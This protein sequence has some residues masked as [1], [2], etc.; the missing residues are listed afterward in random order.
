MLRKTAKYFIN[1]LV[2][3]GPIAI[4][5]YLVVKLF[6]LVDK[7]LGEVIQRH[8][9]VHVYGLGF[10]VTML[11]AV[12]TLVLAGF[13]STHYLARSL[14]RALEGWVGRFPLIK[15]VYNS[16]KDLIGAFVGAKKRFDQPVFVTII[17]GSEAKVLGFVTRRSVGV[18]GL[19][20][21]VA[22]YLPQAYNFAGNLVIVPA[23]QV[24][25][26]HAQATEV[27]TFVVSGGISGNLQPSLTGA[28]PQPAPAA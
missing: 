8:F 2:F 4:T 23:R 12:P 10:I 11:I 15:L 5:V 28:E 27:M 22:V 26:I 25:A 24:T 1:G 19:E 16:L 6:S 7:P 20:E 13:L 9:H 3:V 18:L 14:V 17:P 21:H